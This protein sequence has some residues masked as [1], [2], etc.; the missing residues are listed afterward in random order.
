MDSDER[1]IEYTIANSHYALTE[2]GL[3]FY[4]NNVKDVMKLKSI[5]EVEGFRS[6]EE[7]AQYQ[8][9]RIGNEPFLRILFTVFKAMRNNNIELAETLIEDPQLYHDC[10][11]NDDIEPYFNRYWS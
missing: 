11:A 1:K 7:W 9:G 5:Q 4:I 3:T 8:L 2:R 6:V 10:V